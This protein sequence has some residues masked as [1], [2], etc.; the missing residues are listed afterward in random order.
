MRVYFTIFILLVLVAAGSSFVLT[1]ANYAG[2]TPIPFVVPA[3]WPKPVY[4]FLDN[5][6]TKEGFELGRTL[7]YDG[8][9]SKDGNYPCASCHQQF[10]AFATYDHSLS[11]GYNNS[12]TTRNAPALFNLA[13]QKEFMYDGGVNHLDVQPLVPITSDN[14]MHEV[15]DSIITKL[16]TD[17]LYPK[18]FTA[19][20][21]SNLINTQHITK[22]LSQFL[23]MI[24]SANSYY[25]KVKRG[26]AQF[27][28]SQKLG[29]E[30]FEK[31]CAACHTEPLF[32]D[33]SYRNIGLP[34]DSVLM[35][36]GRM[37]ITRLSADSLKFK[38]PSLRN[39]MVTF[40]YGH[41]GRFYSILDV[42]NHYRNSVV[43]GPTTD[44]LILNMKL[45]NFEIGQ[46]TS[47]LYTLTDSSLL[48]DTRFA[49]PGM[50]DF[51]NAPAADIHRTGR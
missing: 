23:V 28:L 24:V 10:G 15:M 2:A 9:L 22:A 34:V 41:D 7:F 13:W 8:R 1:N 3:G 17:T 12:F 26:E 50:A 44:S 45:S 4:N 40:P 46:I 6:V 35:D 30:I 20:F 5:P 39:V 16:K 19:A 33:L 37:R 29:Y 49:P 36:S 11:H 32:T 48:K 25:D 43:K 27:T 47:F 51:Q 14:E 38:V 31:K 18:L 42:M 21:G